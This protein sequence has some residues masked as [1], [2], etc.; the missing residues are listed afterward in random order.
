SPLFVFWS[1]DGAEVR[2]KRVE[3]DVKNVRFLARNRDAPANRGA[4]NAQIFQTA[5]DEADNFVLAR[6][7]LNESRILF[8]KI[9]QRFLKRRQLEVIILFVDCLRKELTIGAV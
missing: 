3:P 6:F 4:R 9:E 7:R 1:A 2:G 8:V 5:F